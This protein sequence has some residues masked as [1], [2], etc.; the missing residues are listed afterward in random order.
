MR[1]NYPSWQKELGPYWQAA[2]V[3]GEPAHRDPFAV[4]IGAEHASDF[5]DEWSVMQQLP[6]AREALNRL[7]LKRGE[8]L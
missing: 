1:V 8:E 6:V 5:V 3:Q 4:L 2:K 7:V